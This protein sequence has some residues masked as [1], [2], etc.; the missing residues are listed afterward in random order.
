MKPF[1]PYLK[2]IPSGELFYR[3]KIFVPKP[4]VCDNLCP[5]NPG[6]RGLVE[7]SLVEKMA[8]ER[9]PGGKKAWSVLEKMEKK[10]GVFFFFSFDTY[11]D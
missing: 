9:K 2:E 5:L 3:K 7:K 11:Q 8:V 10:P 4:E 1:R 6:K